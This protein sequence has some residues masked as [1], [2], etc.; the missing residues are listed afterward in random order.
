M[1]ISNQANSMACENTNDGCPKGL[2]NDGSA[3]VPLINCVPCEQAV[4][5]GTNRNGGNFWK[6]FPG[7]LTGVGNILDPIL[8]KNSP[9]VYPYPPTYQPPVKE[10]KSGIGIW[11]VIGVL[12]MILLLF[13]IFITKKMDG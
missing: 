2:M 3:P 10:E 4:A 11:V 12:A 6:N 8:N 7:I 1:F 9:V 5:N 13:G